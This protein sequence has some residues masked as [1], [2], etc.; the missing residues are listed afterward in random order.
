MGAVMLIFACTPKDLPFL[1]VSHDS[2]TFEAE[3]G[4]AQTLIIS[5]NSEW[6]MTPTE[7]W[8][9]VSPSAGSGNGTASVITDVNG[10]TDQRS[11]KINVTLVATNT[12]VAVNIIQQGVEVREIVPNPAKFDGTKRSSTTY[13]LLI[14]SFADSDGDGIGDFKGITNQN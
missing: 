11:G 8:I 13:Q 10:T 12:T 7:N 3:G 4:A 6:T 5:S 1:T 2:L 9:H 14:Y